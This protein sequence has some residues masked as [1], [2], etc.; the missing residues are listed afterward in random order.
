[1]RRPALLC[2][3]LLLFAVVVAAIDRHSIVPAAPREDGRFRL[4]IIGLTHAHAWGYLREAAKITPLD[5]LLSETDSPYLAPTP[6][7]GKRNE[8]AYVTRVVETL[9]ELHALPPAEMAARINQNFV[10][11]FGEGQAL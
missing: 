1:M 6:Y 5:R 11:L 4:A 9:S 10:R 3:G 8:P 7:R 2:F